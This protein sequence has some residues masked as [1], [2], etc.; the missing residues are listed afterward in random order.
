MGV[1]SFIAYNYVGLKSNGFNYIKHFFGPVVWLGPLL[2]AIEL[3]SHVFRPLTLGL[4]LRGNIMA[5]HTILE[6]MMS[7]APISGW[8]FY[9]FGL[10]VAFVQAFVFTLLTMVYISL[11]GEHEDH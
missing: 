11:A 8:V 1:I 3:F 5:D 2:F 4:R 9:G 6:V 7:K 10:F